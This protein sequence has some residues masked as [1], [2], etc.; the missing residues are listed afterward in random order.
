MRADL[1]SDRGPSIGSKN[2]V[3]DPVPALRQL[4][5]LAPAIR[6]RPTD[7]DEACTSHC[8]AGAGN[9][10]VGK[11]VV[12]AK[13]AH[14]RPLGMNTDREQNR[15]RVRR[16]TICISSIPIPKGERYVQQCTDVIDG[17]FGSGPSHVQA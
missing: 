10:R 13:I 14:R 15:V 17:C 16:K 5:K 8:K 2:V 3:D 7:L 1:L 6:W 9:A 12:S 4:D 11:A